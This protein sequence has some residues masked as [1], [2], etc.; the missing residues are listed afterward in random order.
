MEL[1]DFCKKKQKKLCEKNM[2]ITI[3][4]NLI[5]IRCK[6]YEKDTSKMQ[7]TNLE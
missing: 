4:S 5:T 1:C 3:Q 2:E 6:E 7:E